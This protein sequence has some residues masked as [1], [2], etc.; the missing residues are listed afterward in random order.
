MT[1]SIWT[2]FSEEELRCS[3][4]CVNDTPASEYMDHELMD[5]LVAIRDAVGYPLQ[6]SSAYRCPAYNDSVSSTGRTGPHTTGGA[7][8][9]LISGARYVE[10]LTWALNMGIEG[11]GSKQK[12]HHGGRFLHI[13]KNTGKGTRGWTY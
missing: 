5:I 12:G 3:C 11:V 9:I 10:V 6:L 4:G 1:A 2:W 13:D 7:V 8:D